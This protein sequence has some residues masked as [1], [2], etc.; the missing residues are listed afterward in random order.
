MLIKTKKW[1]KT[2][3]L[4]K[5]MN[6]SDKLLQERNEVALWTFYITLQIVLLLFVIN[7]RLN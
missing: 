5:Q 3:L 7:D 4:K 2:R 1:F 6:K